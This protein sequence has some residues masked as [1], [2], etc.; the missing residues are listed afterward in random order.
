MTGQQGGRI[1][2]WLSFYKHGFHSLLHVA[3]RSDNGSLKCIALQASQ[4]LPDCVST[5][6]AAN[7]WQLPAEVD[8]LNSLR[9]TKNKN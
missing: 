7:Q 9:S 6:I 1:F 4:Y 8:W 3:Y 2:G 5:V